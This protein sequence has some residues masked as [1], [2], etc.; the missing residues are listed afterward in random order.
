MSPG[1]AINYARLAG[2]LWQNSAV[3]AVLNWIIR[4][5]PESCPCVEKPGDGGDRPGQGG[6]RLIVAHPL[7][8]IL[9]DP[10]PWDDDTTLWAGTILSF[11]CDGNA[12]WRIIRDR[13]G[14]VREFEYVPHWAISPYRAKDSTSPGP[15]FYWMSTMTGRVAVDVWDIVHYR[16]G[17]DPYNDMLGMSAWASVNR[18][19]YTDN[20]A[21]NYTAT[22][23]RNGG[24]AWAFVSPA[25]AGETFDDPIQVRDMIEARTT[26]D[27]LNRVVV[28]DIAT[29]F[30]FPGP[31]KDMG[32]EALRQIPVHRICALAGIAVDSLD[33]GDAGDHVT[34]QNQRAADVKSWNTLV[35]VQRMMGRQLTKQ[36]LWDAHNFNVPRNTL[37][38]GFDQSE[39]RAL[40]EAK[41]EKWKA[42]SDIVDNGILTPTEGRN[43]IGYDA[44]TEEQWKEVERHAALVKPLPPKPA[45]PTALVAG[46][47]TGKHAPSG[48][49]VGRMLREQ[50]A[51][52]F[53]S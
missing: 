26:G 48:E 40:Q 45:A 41:M 51:G 46:N 30:D 49:D 35:S 7:T 5:W 2:D 29:K 42:V 33:L 18:E 16:F 47:G 39:V 8:D 44:L 13:G 34:F 10:N 27:N 52:T 38:A 37:F 9:M 14:R 12:Y 19:V 4:A 1:T 28:M 22:T 21:C 50:L 11:W 15:D 32:I 20:Q 43:E 23:L 3:Q 17:R 25:A 6:K 53:A 24:K 36:V 31:M